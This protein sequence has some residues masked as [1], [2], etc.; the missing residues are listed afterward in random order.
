MYFCGCCQSVRA[1]AILALLGR[2]DVPHAEP[3]AVGVEADHVDLARDVDRRLE[4]V[5]LRDQ[6]RR[7][8][9]AVAR[10]VTR[11][12]A[13]A[14]AMPISISLFAAA[15]T[16]FTHDFAGVADFEID[17]RL[18]RRRSRSR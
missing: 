10:A 6:Q 13:S 3:R 5:G 15:V 18:H 11:R 17:R 16:P 14:S 9:A 12:A 2:V 1:D 4:A 7:R 8:V